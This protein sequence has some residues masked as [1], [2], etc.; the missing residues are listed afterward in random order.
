MAAIP[1][2]NAAAAGGMV[3]MTRGLGT[4]LGVTV[5]TLAL[6]TGEHLGHPDAG[7]SLTMLVLGGCALAA[8]FAARGPSAGPIGPAIPIEPVAYPHRSTAKGVPVVS[9]AGGETQAAGLADSIARLRRA[10]RRAARVANPANQLAV[11]QLE[12]LSALADQ[13]GARPGQLARLLHLRPNT[14]TT[15]VNALTTQGMISRTGAEDDRRAVA[16][17]VT[18][19]GHRV[20]RGWQ[21]TNSTVLQV[22]LSTLTSSQRTALGRAVPALGALATAVDALADGPP[23]DL[24]Y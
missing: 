14:V 21:A 20:V 16:L 24:S 12:L 23:D 13:P 7:A 17:K 3:N 11:A 22:A 8:A 15:L 9:P 6:H 10:L 5:V 18:D 4:A 1:A 19:E 2:R